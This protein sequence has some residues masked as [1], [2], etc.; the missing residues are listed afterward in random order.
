[1]AAT[2]GLAVHPLWAD[3]GDRGT[4]SAQNPAFLK[5]IHNPLAPPANFTGVTNPLGLS[6]NN[7]F[8]RI[9]PANARDGLARPGSSS[10]PDPLGEP[11]AGAPSATPYL[12]DI[13]GHTQRRVQSVA[14]KAL[15][16][17]RMPYGN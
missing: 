16:L 7:A 14:G 4:Y 11:L 8:G 13:S 10:I 12:C 3:D 5:S 9:W 17:R 2:A 6:I 1:M 15:C